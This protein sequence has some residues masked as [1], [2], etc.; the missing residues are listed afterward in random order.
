MQARTRPSGTGCARPGVRVGAALR[1]VACAGLFATACATLS[2][3]A[4]AQANDRRAEARARANEGLALHK[5]GDDA[6]ALLK[7]QQA[8][9]LVPLPEILFDM[10]RAEQLTGH[11]LEAQAAYRKC[12]A[13]SAFSAHAQEARQH[14]E[15]LKAQL[16]HVRIAAPA[17]AA[18]TLDG[19]PVVDWSAPV[20]V[21]PGS[22]TV[23]A[24][25]VWQDTRSVTAVAGQVVDVSIGPPDVPSPAPVA[26]AA[27]PPAAAPSA[28]T[29]PTPSAA[30]TAPEASTSDAPSGSPTKWIVAGSLAGLAVVSVGVGVVFGVNSNNDSNSLASLNA[31]RGSVPCPGAGASLCQNLSNTYNQQK[32][33]STAAGVL[34]VAGG[35]LAAGA[36]ATW[37]LWPRERQAAS[38]WIAPSVGP[39]GAGV[40]AGGRF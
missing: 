3:P 8:Y 12:L 24:T 23:T 34:Y 26:P 16:G 32:Q 35:V 29:S 6:G 37:L 5:K 30:S 31:Q 11:L 15:E 25:N 21:L 38:A 19:Q 13:D 18:V 27:P 7:F 39:Q 1:A 17:H 4:Q 2:A 33:D 10:A 22:H 9:A 20:D 28:Q 40:V 36:V 14:L